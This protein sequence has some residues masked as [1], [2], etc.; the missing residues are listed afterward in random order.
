MTMASLWQNLQ[1]MWENKPLQNICRSLDNKGS[2]RQ[3]T[4]HSYT[5]GRSILVNMLQKDEFTDDEWPGPQE[6]GIGNI[7]SGLQ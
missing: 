7:H 5:S 3:K 6:E 4:N 1:R 2:Y